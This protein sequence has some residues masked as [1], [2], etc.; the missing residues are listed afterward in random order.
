MGTSTPARG[1]IRIV[2]LMMVTCD[3]IGVSAS[4][5]RYKPPP[6]TPHPTNRTVSPSRTHGTTSPT[7][8]DVSASSMG[9]T[10]TG[11]GNVAWASMPTDH[12][13]P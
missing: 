4:W 3:G 13:R 11:A 6:T 2:G 5:D 1:P 10:R 8:V 9:A 7:K 12:L